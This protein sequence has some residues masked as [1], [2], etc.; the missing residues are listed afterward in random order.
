MKKEVTEYLAM[1]KVAIATDIPAHRLIAGEN[2]SI[3]EKCIS[4]FDRLNRF[5]I[6]KSIEYAYPNE[7]NVTNE[8]K[9]IDRTNTRS[10]QALRREEAQAD[11]NKT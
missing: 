7:E 5:E 8:G 4:M 9:S 11:F 2:R 6:A 3:E 10:Y 1:E